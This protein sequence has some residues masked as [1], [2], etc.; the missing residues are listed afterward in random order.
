MGSCL[1]GCQEDEMRGTRVSFPSP[2]RGTV[3]RRVSGGRGRTASSPGFRPVAGSGAPRAPPAGSRETQL[4]GR[5]TRRRELLAE[6]G[7]GPG[8]RR[9]RGPGLLAASGGAGG[10]GRA[11]GGQG[12]ARRTSPRRGRPAPRGS[13][14]QPL[15]QHRGGVAATHALVSARGDAGTGAAPGG[16]HRGWWAGRRRVPGDCGGPLRRD[17]PCPCPL[18]GTPLSSLL[19]PFPGCFQHPEYGN[20]VSRLSEKVVTFS[21]AKEL[22]QGTSPHPHPHPRAL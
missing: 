11:A 4:P 14:S 20:W 1:A 15:R 6:S 18:A 5:V 12:P 17:P 2:R 3:S 21:V 9:G 10:T 8:R 16:G 7:R 13:R 19:P 22:V